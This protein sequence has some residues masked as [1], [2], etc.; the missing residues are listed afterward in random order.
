[1]DSFFGNNSFFSSM[2]SLMGRML[3][4]PFDDFFD[5]MPAIGTVPVQEV[6][7]ERK[8]NLMSCED[9]SRFSYLRQMNA[10]KHAQ[11]KAIHEEDFERAAELRDEIHKLEE[12]HKEAE[13]SKKDHEDRN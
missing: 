4:S 13:A 6:K 11:K 9:Q 7:K 2:P 8:D 5:E 10:L 1:M 3:E 12:A